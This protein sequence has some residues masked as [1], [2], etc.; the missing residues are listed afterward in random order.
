MNGYYLGNGNKRPKLADYKKK[1]GWN[2]GMYYICDKLKYEQKFRE[3]KQ[4]QETNKKASKYASGLS[5]GIL[6]SADS[7]KSKNKYKK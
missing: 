5:W 4:F 6:P 3:R 2:G 1:F 7:V